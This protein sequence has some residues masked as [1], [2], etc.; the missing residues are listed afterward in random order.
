MISPILESKGVKKEEW[1]TIWTKILK[2]W[3]RWQWLLDTKVF[4]I[5]LLLNLSWETA[6]LM[7]LTSCSHLTLPH[8]LYLSDCRCSHTYQ[9]IS[10]FINWHLSWMTDSHLDLSTNKTD[11]LSI[12]HQHLLHPFIPFLRAI[13]FPIIHCCSKTEPCTFY[14]MAFRKFSPTKVLPQKHRI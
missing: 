13:C 3:G 14:Y 12:S 8:L 4:D 9:F 11:L 10:S 5:Q 1:R 7:F 6:V 2:G